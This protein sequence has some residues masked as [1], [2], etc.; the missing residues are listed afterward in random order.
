MSICKN[1][2]LTRKR[3]YCAILASVIVVFAACGSETSTDAVNAPSMSDAES[4]AM[5]LSESSLSSSDESIL[6]Q[7][8]M[9]SS[10]LDEDVPVQ[11]NLS[12]LYS[13]S[14]YAV[15]S[16]TKS[17]S[18]SINKNQTLY[19]TFIDSRDGNTYKYV[20][21]KTQTW[22]AENLNYAD[23]IKSP[24]LEDRSWCYNGNEELCNLFGR[25]YS[26]VAAVDSLTSGC[27]YGVDCSSKIIQGICPDGWHIPTYEDFAT[28]IKNIGFQMGTQYSC[29]PIKSAYLWHE[30]KNG[31]DAYGFNLLPAGQ[32]ETQ[33]YGY[34]GEAK[35]RHITE[36]AGFWGTDSS[37]RKMY[38]F[39]CNWERPESY[40]ISG[41][42]LKYAN[43][44]MKSVRCVKDS[45]DYSP[46][47][48]NKEIFN[49]TIKKETFTDERDEEKYQFVTIGS[50]KW[51]AEN[52]RFDP[53]TMQYYGN[54]VY[55]DNYSCV[56]G[57]YI[58]D[59]CSLTHYW[60]AGYGSSRVYS[61]AG[62]MDS[63][64]T[65]CGYGRLCMEGISKQGI[66]PEGWQVPS[67]EDYEKLIS[68]AGGENIAG[69]FL[70]SN[71]GDEY[72]ADL[73]GFS[74][75]DNSYFITSDEIDK[76]SL[77][78]FVVDSD[79]ARL[80]RAEKSYDSSVGWNGK[81]SMR[82]IKDN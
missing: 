27:G 28:L 72:G 6:I 74:A 22:M 44:V 53:G 9:S 23:S 43:K 46:S 70:R 50:Q 81:G 10:S 82:C 80:V 15:S 42:N 24:I 12:S 20:T 66:C 3:L 41:T 38:S 71:K 47:T 63:V 54:C 76:D 7:A 62:A 31:S 29:S 26:W 61:F 45:V 68:F 55:Y 37:D 79:I 16:S 78:V 21:I 11:I 40:L 14:S 75:E 36:N 58:Q 19:G 64:N 30:K 5:P 17:S 35:F 77:F 18:S 52:L 13:S 60:S 69:F 8:E 56:L 49:T 32:G 34:T 65:L 4:G 67:A 57:C 2:M 48:R 59:T 33:Y 51:M 1:K 25:L 73:Y 39:G